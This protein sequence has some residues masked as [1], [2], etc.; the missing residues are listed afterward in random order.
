MTS[1]T[2]RWSKPDLWI[3]GA[4]VFTAF[5]VAGFLFYYLVKYAGTGSSILGLVIIIPALVIGVRGTLWLMDAAGEQVVI[6]AQGLTFGSAGSPLPWSRIREMR[7]NAGGTAVTAVDDR[8]REVGTLRFQHTNALRGVGLVLRHAGA[9]VRV[10]ARQV[11]TIT[12]KRSFK[13]ILPILA[14]LLIPVLNQAFE[15][16]RGNAMIFL[17]IAFGGAA[18]VWYRQSGLRQLEISATGLKWSSRRGSDSYE[19]GEIAYLGVASED[20]GNGPR[21]TI[22]VL[23]RDGRWS[24]FTIDGLDLLEISALFHAHC[25]QLPPDAFLSGRE[26]AA[27][28]K[29]LGRLRGFTP[30][31]FR[32]S[33]G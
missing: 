16:W 15:G 29:E 33:V 4:G 19:W 17:A 32:G 13:A 2:L 1:A 12:G 26:L 30:H 11:A 25:P 14:V 20:Q 5:L 21:P 23:R 6:D 28:A 22:T 27:K 24:E 8:G 31:I 9:H 3:R 10:P 18:W 7:S